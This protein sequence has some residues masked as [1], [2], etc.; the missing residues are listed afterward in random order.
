MPT[1]IAY[2]ATRKA[3]VSRKQTPSTQRLWDHKMRVELRCRRAKA[4]DKERK[5]AKFFWKGAR[6]STF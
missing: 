4:S 2:G 6:R 5:T 1:E 3:K